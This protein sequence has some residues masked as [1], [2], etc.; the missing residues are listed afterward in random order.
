MKKLYTLTLMSLIA[1]LALANDLRSIEGIWRNQ[2]FDL[3]IS[4]RHTDQGIKV[5]RLD[6]NSW[7]YY[8]LRSSDSYIDTRG[9]VYI[10]SAGSELIYKPAGNG[11]I[12]YF[13]KTVDRSDSWRYDGRGR[14]A[15]DPVAPTYRFERN[16]YTGPELRGRWYNQ[17]TGRRIRIDERRRGISVEFD[18][19]QR[20]FAFEGGNVF[21]D[22]FG[23]AIR[24]MRNGDL[25]YSELGTSRR[26]YYT[27]DRVRRGYCD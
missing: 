2:R 16:R 13:T 20:F 10:V 14:N 4:V 7:Y 8:D 25:R 21:R 6:Q 11:Q 26:R 17:D 22:S 18:R 9:N 1:Q 15:Y 3:E 24:V 23:N 19:R 5:K 27:R 12:I